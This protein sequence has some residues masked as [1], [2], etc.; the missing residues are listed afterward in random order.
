MLKPLFGFDITE[1]KNST[2]YYAELF[3]EKKVD[4]SIEKA[5]DEKAE[6]LISTEQKSSLP[7]LLVIIQ[8]LTLMYGLLVVTSFIGVDGGMPQA[9]RNA[10]IISYS[11]ICSLIAGVTIW[12]VGKVK[13]KR[14]LEEEN[15]EEKLENLKACAEAALTYL[16][17][18]THAAEVDILMFKF[19][20][21]NGKM[22]IHS[23]TW[24]ATP[25][26]NH[27]FKVYLKEY[28]LCIAD[29]GSVYSIPLESLREI[30]KINKNANLPQWNKDVPYNRGEYK[31]F[32][33]GTND[34]GISCKPYYVLVFEHE[35]EE[36]GVYFPK[37]ELP[38]FESLTLLK[39]IDPQEKKESEV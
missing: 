19:S 33:L 4:E 28:K 20:F 18:P 12:L 22:K 36:Y 23:P 31:Q 3:E 21:K 30:R 10:P 16:G 7:S 8:Y 32:K 27:P 26:V 17:V 13:K 6:S 34:A 1:D 2:K 5:L 38:T 25:F 9:I 39:A 15:A 35:G 29:V 11:G 14:V 37:S 24:S